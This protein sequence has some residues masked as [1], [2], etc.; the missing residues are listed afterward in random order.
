MNRRIIL[1]TGIALAVLTGLPLM[2]T[3]IAAAAGVPVKVG[4]LLTL[5]GPAGMFGPAQANCATLAAEEINARGGLAGRPI[6]LQLIDAGVPPAEASQAALRS[7]RGDGIEAFIGTNDSAVRE[8][9][10]G[11]FGGKVPYIYTTL[12]EGGECSPGVQVLG[13]T[14]EQQLAP[15][16]PWLAAQKGLS[17]WYLIGNDYNWPRDTNAK[18][19]EYI[20]AS[21]GTVVGEEYLPFSV[22][23]YDA[24]IAAIRA[25]GADAV[26]ITLVG[27]SSVGFNRSFASFGL[28]DSVTRLSTGIEELTL[29]GIGAAN[30]ANLFASAGYF[31]TIDRDASRAFS[32]RYAARFGPKAPP[33][34]VLSQSAYDGLLL[35]EAMVAK[36]G[37]LDPVALDAAA[38]GVAFD[39]PRGHIV[40]Q[41]RHG[42]RDIY[43][44]EAKDGVFEVIKT[45]TQV[46]AGDNCSA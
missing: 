32:E 30:S 18:A 43:L 46:G 37:S 41:Q 8:A 20:A 45:F 17:K 25:A 23:N 6:Q 15:V 33:L 9:L 10:T 40:M 36:A 24:S 2:K 3:R 5:S 22:D 12:Y 38:E 34:S 1:K 39:G 29:A 26:F 7:W 4:A 35:L 13:E 28:A 11:V 19:K 31:T 21:G 42:T 16:L 44:A 14:P 27:G